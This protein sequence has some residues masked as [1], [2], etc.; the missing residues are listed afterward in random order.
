[1]PTFLD[2]EFLYAT[3]PIAIW[4]EIEM[5]LAITAGSLSTL[6]PLYRIAAQKFSWRTNLFSNRRT[7]PSVEATPDSKLTDATIG[8]SNSGRKSSKL[9]SCADSELNIMRTTSEDLE[10][11]VCEPPAKAKYMSIIKVTNVQVDFADQTANKEIV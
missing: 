6:R 11:E 2:P 7:L 4:S 3:V 8:S 5:S 10:L 9:T 1:V